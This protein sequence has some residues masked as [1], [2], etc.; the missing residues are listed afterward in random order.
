M[1]NHITMVK[2]GGENDP[3]YNKVWKKLAIMAQEAEEKIKEKWRAEEFRRAGAANP[4][5]P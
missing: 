1:A 4:D 5:N 2:F 3:E